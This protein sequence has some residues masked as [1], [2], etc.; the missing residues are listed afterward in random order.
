M[1][2]PKEYLISGDNYYP[3]TVADKAETLPPGAYQI[4]FTMEGAPYFTPIKIVSDTIINIP[5][6]S[7]EEII[8][9]VRKFWSEGVSKKFQEYGKGPRPGNPL[10]PLR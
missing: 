5:N 10:K 3:N 2:K 8:S 9:E 6:S 7:A 4:G 1:A